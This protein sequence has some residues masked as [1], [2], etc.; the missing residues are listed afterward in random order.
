MTTRKSS[1]RPPARRSRPPAR[2][3]AVRA[4]WLVLVVVAAA[5]VCLYPPWDNVWTNFEG[6]RM[7]APL[8]YAFLW[9]PPPPVFPVARTIDIMRLS[10]ELLA[11]VIPGG[12]IYW[13]LGKRRHRR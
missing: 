8:V 4:V 11:V 6:F 9:S 12:L 10:E 2:R 7:H 13:G 1:K 3:G 5:G